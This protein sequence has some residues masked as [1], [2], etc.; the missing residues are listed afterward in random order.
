MDT[1]FLRFYVHEQQ[2]LH[3]KP[4]WEWLLEEANRMGV[5]G[6]S[7]FRAM[8]GFGR[9]RVLHEDR[10]FELQGSLTIEVEFIVTEAEA[11]QLL[12][13]LSREKVRVCYATIPASFGVIDTL[14]APPAAGPAV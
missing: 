13:R 14:S 6:G 9:H 1:V 12:E 8:A 3:W 4:L 2:R 5:A 11:R 7:A 10:F